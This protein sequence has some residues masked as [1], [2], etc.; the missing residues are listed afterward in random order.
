MI[1]GRIIRSSPLCSGSRSGLGYGLRNDVG[2]D[3]AVDVGEAEVAAVV[4]VGE[5]FV[6]EA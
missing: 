1:R 2:D 4:A 3:L 5:A 6:V